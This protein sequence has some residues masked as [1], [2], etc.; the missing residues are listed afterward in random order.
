[1]GQTGYSN[2]ENIKYKIASLLDN[3]QIKYN[4]TKNVHK[5]N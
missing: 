1:M 3:S 4:Q 5:L 2:A